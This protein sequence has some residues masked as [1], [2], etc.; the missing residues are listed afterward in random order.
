MR[1]ML[2]VLVL[3]LSAC[4]TA[5]SAALPVAVGGQAMPT[6]APMLDKATPAVVNI[7]LKA[8]DLAS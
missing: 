1:K 3:T 6:L 7:A 2:A 8:S 5:A 4:L